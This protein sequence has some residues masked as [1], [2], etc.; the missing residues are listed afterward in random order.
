MIGHQQLQQG[1]AAAVGRPAVADAAQV[2]R[3]GMSGFG[4]V[5]AA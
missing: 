4:A 3:A 2:R 5:G 1:N